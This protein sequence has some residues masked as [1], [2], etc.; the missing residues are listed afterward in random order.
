MSRQEM[1]KQLGDGIAAR[2][3]SMGSRHDAGRASP[4]Q[5]Q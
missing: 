3:G 1:K 4:F 5:T 2:K